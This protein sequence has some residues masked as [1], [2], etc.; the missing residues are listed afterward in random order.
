YI[1]KPSGTKPGY[2]DL[3]FVKKISDK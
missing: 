3:I 1:Y 2:A